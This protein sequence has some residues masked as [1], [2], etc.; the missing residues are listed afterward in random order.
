MKQLKTVLAILALILTT[1]TF[2][3]KGASKV[4]HINS[5]DLLMALPER[6]KIQEEIEA[7]AKQ[8]ESQLKVMTKEYETKVAEY[9][10]KQEVMTDVIKETKIKEITDLENRI[11]E[12]Q[13]KAQNDL[14]KK[15]SEL[16]QPIIDKAKKA[17]EDVAKENGYTYILDTSLGV[18]L[19]Q[20][21]SNDIIDLVKK[22]LGIE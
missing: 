12:F 7:Y 9:Q 10:S 14:Q 2:A 20:D 13:Q 17:I 11:Q 6:N 4:G 19:Y 1:T 16:L 18:V 8:L 21:P 5:N 3:Q 15:E 22:K